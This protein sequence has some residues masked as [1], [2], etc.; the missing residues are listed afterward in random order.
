MMPVAQDRGLPTTPHV[1]VVG[2]RG[3]CLLQ[4]RFRLALTCGPTSLSKFLVGLQVHGSTG[5]IGGSGD[6]ATAA[7]KRGRH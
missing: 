4:P 6:P 3:S 5:D 1:L 7:G 2:G